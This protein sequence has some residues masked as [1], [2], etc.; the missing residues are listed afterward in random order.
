VIVVDTG[1]I[2]AVADASDADHDA[3]DQ[4]LTAYLSKELIVP[5]T[6]IVES[7]WLIEDRLGPAAEA[8]FLRSVNSAELTRA[9]LYDSDW[10][11]CVELLETYA[12]LRLGLVDASI[13]AVAERLGIATIATLRGQCA[14]GATS[15]SLQANGSGAKI[16]QPA[17]IPFGCRV[18]WHEHLQ[19]VTR[20]R[21]GRI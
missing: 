15:P 11:R 13:V 12:D 19:A 21:G 14:Y 9:D 3:C 4:L 17:Q 2:L 6:V 20:S 16:E 10:Q 8:A 1:V 18:C 5:T 7:S